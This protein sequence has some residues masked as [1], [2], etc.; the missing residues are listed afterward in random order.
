MV[1]YLLFHGSRHGGNWRI[2]PTDRV[3][4]IHGK[5]GAGSGL[6]AA[7]V[8]GGVANGIQLLPAIP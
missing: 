4:A 7:H 1:V 8:P 6:A 2:D 5:L 3:R